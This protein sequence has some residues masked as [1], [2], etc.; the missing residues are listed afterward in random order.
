MNEPK[1]L[2][3]NKKLTRE[4]FPHQAKVLLKWHQEENENLN[5]PGNTSLENHKAN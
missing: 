5:E 1:E 2:K 4:N 3:S